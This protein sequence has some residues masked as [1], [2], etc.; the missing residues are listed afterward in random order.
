MMKIGVVSDT[1]VPHAAP[2]VPGE[3]LEA[4]S[5]EGV[6]LILHAGD[7]VVEDVLFQLMEVAPV[8]AVAGNVDPPSVR[9]SYSDVELF[10]VEGVRILLTHGWG[11]GATLPHRLLEAYGSRGARVVVFGHSHVPYNRERDG[12]LLFNPGSPTCPRGP[13]GRSFGVLEVDEGSVSGS[14]VFID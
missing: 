8:R 4:L 1:H 2:R 6:E 10:E 12:V 3:V 5:K 13:F 11:D 7:M 14:I 9:A